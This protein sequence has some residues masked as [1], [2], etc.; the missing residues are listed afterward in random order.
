MPNERRCAQLAAWGSAWLAGSVAFD[1]VLDAVTG[2]GRHVGGPGFGPGP[3]P[4]G[5]ALAEWKRAG[6]SVLVLALPVPGDIR[7]LA[8][9]VEFRTA[10]LTAGEAVF[11]RDFGL[12]VLPGRDTPSSAGREL[13]WHRAE[14]GEL[15]PDPVSMADAEH[16]LAESIRDTASLFARRGITS[17][18]SDIAPALSDARR[19]GERLH[20][21]A[22]HPPRGVRLIAQAERLS[23]VLTV[24]DSDDTGQLTARAVA[25]REQALAPLRLAVRRALL[26]GYNAAAED[27]SRPVS[28]GG[29]V[30]GSSRPG[31]AVRTPPADRGGPAAGR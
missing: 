17:W 20:L 24:V 18:L 28:P 9:P 11:G 26:A 31:S 7:G 27:L 13:I 15:P 12:T 16:D 21:P 1:D 2:S 29:P 8:G 4:V 25:E 22:S 3:N 30:P 10:A 23:A 14:V 19:A 5:T 6:T